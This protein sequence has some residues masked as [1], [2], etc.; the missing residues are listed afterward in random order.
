MTVLGVIRLSVLTVPRNVSLY[1]RGN[2][3]FLHKTYSSYGPHYVKP[4]VTTEKRKELIES[5]E[6]ET[7]KLIPI[8]AALNYE[9]CS[10]FHDE[11]TRKFTN[12]VMR[13]GKKALARELIE[14]TFEKIK[15]IQLEKYHKTPE[16]QKES[17]IK[18]PV[19]ILHDA[20]SNSKPLL[21]LTPVKRGGVR[22]QVPVPITENRSLFLAIKW[23]ITSAKD[24][25]RKIH[26]PEKLAWELLDA[27]ANQ[28]RVVKRKV[29][30]HRQC[31]ANK[32]FAHYRW[33]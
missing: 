11:L 10:V 19:K 27:A 6:A 5:G 18:D 28:G 1:R 13:C 20:I 15:R 30:L 7:L 4:H 29:D 32:A 24:K 17:I 22:Y 16:D 26:F 25:D 12:H 33:S 8:K 3:E 2:E 21:E 23:L 31:E 9:T 14:K